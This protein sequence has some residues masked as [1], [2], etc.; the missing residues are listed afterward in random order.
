MSFDV[1]QASIAE[2]I[3]TPLAA[4]SDDEAIDCV[5]HLIDLATYEQSEA[6]IKRA[7]GML[8]EIGRRQLLPSQEALL[9]YFRANACMGKRIIAGETD[10]RMWEQPNR[11]EQILA[12]LMAC[13]HPGFTGLDEVR[14]CQIFTNL[15]IQLN[16][17]GRFVEAI[18]LWDRALTILPNFAMAHGSR[19]DGLSYYGRACEDRYDIE[20][21][22]LF[23]QKSF[24]AATVQ[25]ALWDAVYPPSFRIH[26]KNG[27]R[28]IEERL[29]LAA[30]EADFDLD[31]PSLGRSSDERAYR[32]WALG[33]RLF[34]NPL[35]D[36]GPHAVAASDHLMLPSL[37]VGIEERGLP[38]IIG[39][40][41][42]M[43]QEYAF[44]RLLLYE[45]QPDDRLH[46][47]DRGV[48]LSNTLDYPSFSIRTEKVRTAFRLAYS[49]LDKVGYFINIY[50]R[51]GSEPHRVGFRSVWYDQSGDKPVLHK[52]FHDYANWPLHGLFWLSKDLFDERFQR[53]TNADARE[54]FIIR[55]HL[56]HKWLHINEGWASGLD[57]APITGA[58]GHVI[59]SRDFAT[60]TLHLLKIARAAMIYLSLA[61]RAEERVRKKGTDTTFVAEMPIGNWDDDWKR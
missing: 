55:N 27:A 8:K 59:A 31:G 15:G 60:K 29:D 19:G 43:K 47:A 36:L 38:P 54:I 37:N 48:R 18:E 58:I 13:N 12:L 17:V 22:L 24:H 61:V 1:T 57:G 52:R 6:G 11:Q 4:M 20:I 33:H 51:L 30:I 41:S 49:L 35:N 42:Q 34:L 23:A 3:R 39:F 28:E 45:G 40:Y 16:G 5:G 56:E 7:L 26:F 2:L 21:L 14:R 44:A 50:W 9:H 46:F 10:S 25:G 32:R 53:V